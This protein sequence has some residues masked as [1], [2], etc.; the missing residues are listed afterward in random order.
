MTA[1]IILVIRNAR[2]ISTLSRLNEK[3]KLTTNCNRQQ[4]T[5]CYA[6]ELKKLSE[7]DEQYQFSKLII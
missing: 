6:P 3:E 7:P 4:R 1:I 2:T 5:C